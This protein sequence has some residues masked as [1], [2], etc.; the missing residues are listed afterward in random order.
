MEHELRTYVAAPGRMD[1]LLA[2]FREHTIGLFERHG[3]RSVA[4]WTDRDRPD[5]LVYLVAH[6]GDPEQS[7]AAFRAD[8]EWQEVRERSLA[9]GPLTLSIES[10]YLAPAGIGPVP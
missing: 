3:I 8:P 7:W 1:D 9:E 5:R 6:E 2:R 4:Y 10:V